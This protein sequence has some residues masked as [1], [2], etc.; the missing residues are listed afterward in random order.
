MKEYEAPRLPWYYVPVG[1]LCLWVL[2]QLAVLGPA[3]ACIAR[4]AGGRDAQRVTTLL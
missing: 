2:G 3:L 4:A 1:F